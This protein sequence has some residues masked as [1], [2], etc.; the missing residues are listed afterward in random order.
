M[1][2]S[3]PTHKSAKRAKELRRTLTPSEKVL[4]RILRASQKGVRFRRQEPI[5]PYIV[6]FVS[7]DLMLIIEADGDHHEGSEHDK[8]RDEYLMTRGFRVRRFGNRDVALDPDWVSD[9]ID[10]VIEQLR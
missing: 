7:F 2:R 6:D 10:R 5:G 9:V 1:H 8:R 4:W 3:E